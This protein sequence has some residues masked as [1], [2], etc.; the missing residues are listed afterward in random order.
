MLR[1]YRISGSERGS[2]SNIAMLAGGEASRLLETEARERVV[3]A[4]EE[5]EVRLAAHPAPRRRAVRRADVGRKRASYALRFRLLKQN[6]MSWSLFSYLC[7]CPTCLKHR[8]A[9][10]RIIRRYVSSFKA[11]SEEEEDHPLC[12][13]FRVRTLK[14]NPENTFSEQ[15][16]PDLWSWRIRGPPRPDLGC[17]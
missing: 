5:D 3:L 15:K 12:L 8:R 6:A 11:F 9:I 16:W 13:F 1:I 7:G 2:R 4:R 10:R 14:G 17:E